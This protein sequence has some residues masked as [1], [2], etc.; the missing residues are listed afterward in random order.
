[1]QRR[2]LLVVPTD[3][4]DNPVPTRGS[5]LKLGDGVMEPEMS[6][7]EESRQVQKTI[8]AKG[9]SQTVC[10]LLIVACHL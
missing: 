2:T 9:L 8:V 6:E 1:M 3:R 7:I 5:L 10:S 4:I